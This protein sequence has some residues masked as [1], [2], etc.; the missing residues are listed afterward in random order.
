M[1]R[2]PTAALFLA[3]AVVIMM[4]CGFGTGQSVAE[5]A[6][7]RSAPR[8][9]GPSGFP[10]PRFV[11]LRGR[12]INLRRGPSTSHPIEWVYRNFDGLPVKVVAETELWRRVEDHE[13][14]VGW[15]HRGLLDGTRRALIAADGAALRA[16]PSQVAAI[17]AKIMRGAIGRIE[18]CPAQWCEL[19]FGE[20]TGWVER[21]A[22]WGILPDERID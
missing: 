13:G 11:S 1:D 2:L 15:V 19:T 14:V 17:R 21:E 6:G 5:Q 22:V 18:Q 12:T 3:I 16:A 8:V 4:P 10:V 20:V 7:P 9:S